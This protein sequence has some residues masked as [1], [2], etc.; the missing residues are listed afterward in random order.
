MSYIN[1][2]FLPTQDYASLSH[3]AIV[4][5][6][7]LVLH[8]AAKNMVLQTPSTEVSSSSFV[9]KNKLKVSQLYCVYCSHMYIYVFIFYMSN[10]KI[11]TSLH[12]H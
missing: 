8:S 11:F 3:L 1:C 2:F 9:L 12:S 4:V 7:S 10:V 6:A 5:R